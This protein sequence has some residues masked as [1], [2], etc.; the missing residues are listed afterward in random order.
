M[1]GDIS[2]IGFTV[3]EPQINDIPVFDINGAGQHPVEGM[4]ILKPIDFDMYPE[5]WTHIYELG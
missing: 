1:K 3:I 4:F 2:S 5:S